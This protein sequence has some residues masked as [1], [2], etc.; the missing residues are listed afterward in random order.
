MAQETT[1][2]VGVDSRPAEVGARRAEAALKKV[3]AQARKT[4]TQFQKLQKSLG[5][6]R[7]LFGAIG[8]GIV[9]REFAQLI[10]S[11][12]TIDNRLK[13]VTNTAGEVNAVFAELV[14]ISNDTRTGLEANAQLFGRLALATKDLGLTFKEQLDLTRGLNQ[15][16]IISGANAAEGSAGLIQLGQ[17]LAAG[18]LRGDELRSVLEQLPKVAD[19]IAKGLGITRGEL[20]AFGTQGK[21]TAKAVV[22]AFKKAADS[23]TEEFTKITPTIESAFIVLKNKALELTRSLNHAAGVG[24]F[25]AEG[26]L[27]I[28]DNFNILASVAAGFAVILGGVVIKAVIGFGIALASNPIG[29]FI[30]AVGVLTTALGV[31]GDSTSKINGQVVTGW[32]QIRAAVET[33]WQFIQPVFQEWKK[34]WDIV[35][36]A[37]KDFVGKFNVDL[38]GVVDTLKRWASI[39]IGI[40]GAVPKAI[41]IVFED[42]PNGIEAI[43]KS[44]ANKLLDFRRFVLDKIGAI[45][46]AIARIFGKDDLAKSLDSTVGQLGAALEVPRFKLSKDAQAISDRLGKLFENSMNPKLLDNFGDAWEKNLKKIADADKK[47]AANAALLE[48]R[49]G[50]M[51]DKLKLNAALT[52]ERNKFTKKMQSDFDKLREATGRATEVTVEWEMK[53]RESLKRLQLE[54]SKYAAQFEELLLNKMQAARIKD[55]E[56]TKEWARG[57]T[58]AQRGVASSIISDFEEIR[59]ARGENLVLLKE[60]FEQKKLLLEAAGLQ[61]S[62]FA[63][64]VEAIYK[65]QLPE[66]RR[67]D[68]FAAQDSLSGMKQAMVEYAE[69]LG[70]AAD[71]TKSLFKDAFSEM[72]DALTDFVKTGKLDFDSLIQSMIDNLIRLGIQQ[73]LTAAFSQIPGVGSSFGSGGGGGGIG[74]AIT[75]I[76]SSFF[77]DGGLTN[78]RGPGTMVPVSAFRNAPSFGA[79]GVTGGMPAILHKNE[80]V[81]PLSKGRKVPVDMGGASGQVSTIINYNITTP[82]SDSFL[83]SQDQITARASRGLQRAN[84]RNN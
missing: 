49:I 18:A 30:I 68:L 42:L 58:E 31:F 64:M 60:E 27:T 57:L 14:S 78:D 84:A 19:V 47:A 6:F 80:A 36:K 32:Q 20:R 72:T 38:G 56:N 76:F 44:A 43:F 35:S 53:T 11:A 1:L 73:A 15:A 2:R 13:L 9:V 54:N 12:T 70:T 48:G 39:V 71:Q 51:N 10:D 66:A 61:E 25:F 4:E 69:S 63:A 67:A 81:I 65:K 79:G 45:P 8:V 77:K 7:T 17:G 16:L 62:E 46:G 41:I 33:A 59:R 37:V 28:A 52:K 22:D 75:S 74:G 29:L 26:I 55:V 23:L 50:E 40:M 5:G 3:G 24:K 83:R 82:N 34:L 21:I